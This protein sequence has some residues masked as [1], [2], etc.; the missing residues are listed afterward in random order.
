MWSL[1]KRNAR[2]GKSAEG[3]I[4][5]GSGMRV[6]SVVHS[7]VWWILP[8]KRWFGVHCHGLY[9]GR[10]FKI[11]FLP[12]TFLVLLIMRKPVKPRVSWGFVYMN[13]YL[14]L[15]M[16]FYCYNVCPDIFVFAIN[17]AAYMIHNLGILIQC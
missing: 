6:A 9:T 11:A 8:L 1:Q 10:N 12:S 17:Q 13:Y 4:T 3:I 14:Y 16:C 2:Q 15:H 5:S 7:L